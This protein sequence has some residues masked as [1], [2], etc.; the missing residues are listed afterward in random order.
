M[1][2]PINRTHLELF[3]GLFIEGSIII[4]DVDELKIMPTADVKVTATVS[5]GEFDG[6]STKLHVDV[7]CDDRN[8]PL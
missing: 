4:Q 6:T 8:A 7:V 2:Y 5:R 3:P 1:K